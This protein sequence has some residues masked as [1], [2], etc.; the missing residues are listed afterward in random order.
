MASNSRIV[1]NKLLHIQF[2]YDSRSAQRF[3]AK[4]KKY[5][6]DLE[7]K[8]GLLDRR[9]NKRIELSTLPCAASIFV[10]L[11]LAHG[12]TESKSTNM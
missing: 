4:E 3:Q 6:V 8:L 1:Y 9:M 7:A 10:P 2:L 5:D 12:V 11:L